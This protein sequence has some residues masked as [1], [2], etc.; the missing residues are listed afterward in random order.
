MSDRSPNQS[1]QLEF[2]FG[3]GSRGK[4]LAEVTDVSVNAKFVAP[5]LRAILESHSLGDLAVLQGKFL[6]TGCDQVSLMIFLMIASSKI[7][8]PISLELVSEWPGIDAALADRLLSLTNGSTKTIK[9]MK[10]LYDTAKKSFENYTLLWIRHDEKR[11]FRQTL[12]LANGDVNSHSHL[13]GVF[14]VTDKQSPYSPIG[15]LITLQTLRDG[16]QLRGC[17]YLYS[18]EDDQQHKAARQQLESLLHLVSEVDWPRCPF[19]PYIAGALTPEQS[20]TF[21]RLLRTIAVLRALMDTRL[22]SPT[23]PEDSSCS[24]HDYGVAKDLLC[25]LPIAGPDG[26]LSAHAAQTATDLFHAIKKGTLK[27]TSL[28]DQ[29]EFGSDLFDRTSAM[30]TT[31]LAYNTI[32]K[33]FSELEN[34]GVLES[35]QGPQTRGR[36]RKIYF[37][38]APG[39]SP[40]FIRRNPYL[41]LPGV[42]QIASACR[43]QAQ[44]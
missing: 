20:I 37:R 18:S 42:E 30:Q 33:R 41:A 17:G 23:S 36:G 24:I 7:G 16:R 4:V 9:T 2:E 22:G 40:P 8:L 13:P 34:D 27:V 14:T 35:T 19:E 6:K 1:R 3:E 5:N 28:A 31:G 39:R 15:P 44:T 38:F 25:L 12:E 32:K 21:N 43:S 11:L 29:S 10:D 26:G